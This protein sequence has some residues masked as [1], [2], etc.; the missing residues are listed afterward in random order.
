MP[1]TQRPSRLLYLAAALTLVSAS[2]IQPGWLLERADTC[3]A[4]S[5][6]CPQAGLPA[7]FCCST[8]ETC[9]VLAGNT[10]VVCCPN[11]SD[12][13][14]IEPISCNITLQDPSKFPSAEVK[15]TEVD[16]KLPTCA[17]GCC[18]FGFH[19]DEGSVNCVEDD[20]QS[21]KPGGSTSPSTSA[22]HP[23]ATTSSAHTSTATTASSTSPTS[24]SE[25]TAAKTMNTA[26]VVGG[27]IGGLFAF[28]LVAGG[29]FFCYRRNR[30]S[31][32]DEKRR[33]GSSSIGAPI[34]GN[35]MPHDKYSAGRQVFVGGTTGH[36]SSYASSPILA[37]DRFSPRSPAWQS[38]PNG[39]PRDSID[40]A[41]F[42]RSHHV[43]AEP[44]PLS[45][46]R[47]LTNRY[48]N[49]TDRY[50]YGSDFEGADAYRP[51][52]GSGG[53]GSIKVSLDTG[54]LNDRPGTYWPTIH[55]MPQASPVSQPQSP[56]RK[57]A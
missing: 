56:V 52:E 5:S 7:N 14:V 17:N 39:Y 40:N 25:T 43:S 18:P 27:V 44:P 37:Q 48:S 28:A 21:L 20:D 33:S 36:S 45:S 19:C 22:T 15:T 53:S 6:K 30:K 9:L 41:T 29:V 38:A 50:S 12:C 31:A 8:K 4:G 13:S 54:K 24:S 47:N 34:I 11:G 55:T 23:T 3:A 51:R 32:D 35:P 10:T 49:G 26:A 16:L 1:I 2:S 57:R 42:A 46:S